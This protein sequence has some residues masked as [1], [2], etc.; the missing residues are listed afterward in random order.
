MGFCRPAGY[1]DN[2]WNTNA[3]QTINGVTQDP[4]T[5]GI[6]NAVG[7]TSSEMKAASF[8]TLLNS[9]KQSISDLPTGY[10]ASNWK[11]DAGNSNQGYPLLVSST[12]L[13]LKEVDI[14]QQVSV[15]PVPAQSHVYLETTTQ[16]EHY[17]LY[18]ITG[19]CLLLEQS[20]QMRTKID[21]QELPAGIYL[22][23]IATAEG[24]AVRK[25]I[26]N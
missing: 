9:N 18:D 19:V 26:K 16:M 3:A 14:P 2:Y 24:T 25:I 10:S 20:V 21:I 15:Y 5:G 13:S 6:N 12:V 23:R 11:A 7:K 4:K 8:V 17:A 22:L 1:V